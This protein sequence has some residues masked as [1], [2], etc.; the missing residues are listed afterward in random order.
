VQGYRHSFADGSHLIQTDNQLADDCLLLASEGKQLTNEVMHA[1]LR[2]PPAL[3]GVETY[4]RDIVTAFPNSQSVVCSDLADH[5]SWGRLS[6]E[7]VGARSSNVTTVRARRI[8]GV[9]G[10]PWLV[11]LHG[12][13][14]RWTGIVHGHAMYYSTF[15]VPL[16]ARLRNRPLVLSPYAHRRAGRK[17]AGYLSF[18]NAAIRR[19]D[20][21]V[22]LTEY[23]RTLAQELMPRCASVHHSIVPPLVRAGLVREADQDLVVSVG[24]HDIGK[25]SQD[26]PPWPPNCRLGARERDCE[27]WGRAVLRQTGCWPVLSRAMARSRFR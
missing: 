27:S 8:R 12:T 7:E 5:L 6:H 13:L 4:V 15:D 20:R 26:L 23:E 25:G 3:G 22:F 16:W 2:Y 17:Q 14:A 21:L 9:S 19:A 24:R 10:Y 18:I 1:T 11:G